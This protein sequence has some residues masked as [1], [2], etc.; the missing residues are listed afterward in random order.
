MR[1]GLSPISAVSGWRKNPHL[2]DIFHSAVI[3]A[4][5]EL[6]MRAKI[7]KN[8]PTWTSSAANH[9]VKP[10][11][12]FMFSEASFLRSGPFSRRNKRSVMFRHYVTANCS[13]L[14]PG[15]HPPEQ[16]KKNSIISSLPGSQTDR[17]IQPITAFLQ[18]T[19]VICPCRRSATA[20]LSPLSFIIYPFEWTPIHQG[21]HN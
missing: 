2:T 21:P 1:Q 11:D 10:C 16:K 8:I 9:V 3:L 4:E 12:I 19:E 20:L 7:V 17:Q 5:T 18:G 15:K 14:T 13:Y 6:Y